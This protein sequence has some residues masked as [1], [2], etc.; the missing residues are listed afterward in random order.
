MSEPQNNSY[1]LNLLAPESASKEIEYARKLI[2][3]SG[4]QYV[5]LL[6]IAVSGL[7]SF[8]TTCE[9][10]NAANDSLKPCT[11]SDAYKKSLNTEFIVLIILSILAIL[12]GAIL[13]WAL[14]KSDNQRNLITLGIITSGFF[15]IIYAISIRFQSTANRIKIGVSWISFL[16]FIILGFILSTKNVKNE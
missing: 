9:A 7:A 5:V 2:N 4:W 13:A 16:A 1:L 8:V 12:I 10:L 3:I 11:E 6:G 15:G 14:R